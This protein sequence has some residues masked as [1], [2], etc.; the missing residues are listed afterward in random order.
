[1]KDF[2]FDLAHEKLSAEVIELLQPVSYAFSSYLGEDWIINLESLKLDSENLFVQEISKKG[3]EDK[4][5]IFYSIVDK[6]VEHLSIINNDYASLLFATIT[7]DSYSELLGRHTWT[8]KIEE[9]IGK[10]DA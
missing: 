10:N 8:N 6:I 5:K 4:R 3:Q 2:V 9:H 7:L 1:M